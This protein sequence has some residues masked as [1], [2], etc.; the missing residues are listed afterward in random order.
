M[1]REMFWPLSALV[2]A[3]SLSGEWHLI[4][5]TLKGPVCQL[6]APSLRFMLDYTKRSCDI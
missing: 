1:K 5:D 4:A 3:F 6:K 2:L